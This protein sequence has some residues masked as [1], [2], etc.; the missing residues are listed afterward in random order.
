M[1]R[2]MDVFEGLRLS[3]IKKRFLHAIRKMFENESLVRRIIALRAQG[4]L[5]E[6][7]HDTLAAKRNQEREVW[8]MWDNRKSLKLAV[9]SGSTGMGIIFG[10]SY[11]SSTAV[12][13][14]RFAKIGHSALDKLNTGATGSFS[15]AKFQ[16]RASSSDYSRSCGSYGSLRW[17]QSKSSGGPSGNPSL[18]A[19]R[20]RQC[21]INWI[22]LGHKTSFALLF[23]S[24]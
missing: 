15:T 6:N 18:L 9:M 19:G 10:T 11:L 21:W 12:A 17:L 20:L 24:V 23:C 2:A 1:R 8:G 7:P 14:R 22:K 16:R 13:R 4:H 5:I 3:T